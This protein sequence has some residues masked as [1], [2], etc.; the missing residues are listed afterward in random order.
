[1]K[2]TF[3]TVQGKLFQLELAEDAKVR[4]DDDH[5]LYT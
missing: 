5:R 2:V 3:R 1:M 4:V